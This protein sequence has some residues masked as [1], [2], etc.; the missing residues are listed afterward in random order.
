MTLD[1]VQRAEVAGYVAALGGA[2]ALVTF[3][4]YSSYGQPFGTLN[5]I[6]LLGMTLAIA[7]MMLGA[8]ELGGVTPLWPARVSLA[9]GIGAVLAGSAA[10]ALIVAGAV[11]FDGER[12]ASGAFAVEALA[13]I[14]VGAWLIGAPLL[15]GPWLPGPL[16]WLGALSGLG[17]VVFGIGLVHGGVDDPLT[18][19]GGIG[20]QILFPIWAFL[21]A[22]LLGMRSRR[23]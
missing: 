10:Q 15:A 12:P 16:R 8:Y 19:V 23:T 6:F 21:F 4:L 13:L 3:A 22:R 5:D 18:Y 7:P 2:G 20:Y 1:R 17:F 11:T 9:T 14:V